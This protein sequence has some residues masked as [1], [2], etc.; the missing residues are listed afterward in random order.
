MPDDRFF[1]RFT[2]QF[3]FVPAAA[4]PTL[5]PVP[6]P[7]VVPVSRDFY[8]ADVKV[9]MAYGIEA[10][11]FTV[12]IAGLPTTL[13]D[14]IKIGATIVLVRLGYY[15]HQTEAVFEGLVLKKSKRQR[16]CLEA[17]A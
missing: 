7:T 17:V 8:E 11:P 3:A 5:Q 14:T 1:P 12:V 6:L 15:G 9:D 10:N 2:V 4:G 13:Y 16:P